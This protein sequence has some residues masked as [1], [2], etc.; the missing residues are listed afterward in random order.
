MPDQQFDVI[1]V[2]DARLVGGGNKSLAQEI[3]AHSAAGYTTGLLSLSSPARGGARP[4]DSSI[5]ELVNEGLVTMIRPDQPAESGLVIARGPSIFQVDQTFRPQIR[6]HKWLIVANAFNTDPAVTGMLYNP[7]TVGQRAAELFGHSWT[8]VPLSTI[9]RNNMSVAHPKLELSPDTWSNII[10]VDDWRIDRPATLSRPIRIGRHSRDAPGKWPTDRQEIADAYPNDPD[11]DV[12]IMGGS[13]TPAAIL[14]EIPS[15]WTVLPFGTM[16]PKR[17]LRQVDVF[18]Y[19]HH[20]NFSEAFGR[21]ILEAM[22]TGTIAI[23]P[24]YFESIFGDAAIYA[25]PSEVKS[26]ARRLADD[27]DFLA[28]CRQRANE[29]IMQRFSYSTHVDRLKD[30][31][32][33]PR[34]RSSPAGKTIALE[35]T[36]IP[37][38][39]PTVLFYTDNGHGLGHVTRLM[40]YAKRLPDD[41]QPY[42]LTMSKAYHIVDSMGFPVE[43]F[44]SAKSMGFTPAQKPLWEE[45][46]NIRLR[47]LLDRLKPAAVV[48]DHVNPPEVIRTIRADYPDTEFIWS[49][50]G[51]WRQNRKPPGLRMAD[52]FDYVVEPTDLSSPVDMGLTTR[53]TSG[54]LYAPPI[55]LIQRDELLERASAR[56]TLGLPEYGT[57]ILLNLSAD[58][59]DELVARILRIKALLHEYSS[60]ADQPTIFAPRHALH[61]TSLSGIE[62]IVMKPVYP[63]AR[64][65]NA[66]DAAISTTG[67]NSFHELVHLG[68][69]TV[70]IARATET[71]DDQR[72]RAAFASV[73][74]FGAYA[75]NTEGIEF[76]K[77]VS[78][79]MNP[80]LRRRMR[81]AAAEAYPTNGAEVAAEF[82]AS[83]AR[84][85]LP[86]WSTSNLVSGVEL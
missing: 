43:Y 45:L 46:L 26:I 20:P 17:F 41:V 50:R 3:R 52:S 24:R 22:A 57:V 75:E 25:E 76:E 81:L 64:F 21:A 74:G 68:V 37:E 5:L 32:G 69:P 73:A 31:I 66:F 83:V 47:L 23:L 11:F 49:R 62:G 42:F 34:R 72:R 15:N 59:T 29:T 51:L 28:H 8:W 58:S 33:P 4:L 14:G 79:I 84:G 30:L 1:V 19:F 80:R 60:G 35:R 85:D 78:S 12:S 40:A 9:V 82:I 16:S 36:K 61:S 7:I 18:P 10:N 86:N 27:A 77:A 6:A 53:L 65:A 71:L 63:V 13:K 38:D 48:V 2:T 56:A 70:F 44:A 55:T 54:T 67:Y 39:K